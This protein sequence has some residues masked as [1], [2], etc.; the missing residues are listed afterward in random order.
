MKNKS[1]EINGETESHIAKQL[2]KEN[3]IEKQVYLD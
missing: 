1:E 2:A 3:C